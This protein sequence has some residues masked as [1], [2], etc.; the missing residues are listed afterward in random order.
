METS[1]EAGA[2]GRPTRA[3][4]YPS[5]PYLRLRHERTH[6]PRVAS[7]HGLDR[8]V[9][10]GLIEGAEKVHYAALVSGSHRREAPRVRSQ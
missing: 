1:C 3:T 2:E 4:P 6:G 8:P 10:D 9:R 5:R 7:G